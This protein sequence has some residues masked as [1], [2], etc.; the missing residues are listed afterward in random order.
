MLPLLR[1]IA[2]TLLAIAASSALAQAPAPLVV[3]ANDS[4]TTALPII[5]N[6][7][8]EGFLLIESGSGSPARSS[9]DRILGRTA[10]PGVGA[11]INIP[12]DNGR[13]IGTSLTLESNP[14]VGLLC[15]GNS[16]SRSF[17]SLAQHCMVANLSPNPAPP[18]AYSRPGVRAEARLE[19]NRS[20]LTASLGLNRFDIETPLAM[21]GTTPGTVP[22]DR[23][24]SLGGAEFEQ[25]N[26]GLLGE[27]KVGES[28][29]V[30]IG[31]NLARARI[32]PA[33]QLPGGVRPEWNTGTLS[34]GGG[35]G[36]F[37]GEIIGRVI[38]IPGSSNSYSNVGLGVTWRAP[39][40]A[41]LSV[42]AENLATRGKNPFATA[43]KDDEESS[44]VP[45]IRYEQDL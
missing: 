24:L 33:S 9:L 36:N 4:N 28:G 43:E 20:A 17:G 31:G 23:L 25:E 15:N 6:N 32:V 14:T 27:I 19:G 37:G 26:I 7:Q 44:R 10:S 18:L 30:S 35:V 8:V 3:P 2:A 22:S 29:W 12:L 41:R 34:L 11:G 40:R 42:G 5:R 13:R 16:V 38:E 1:P 45:Y 21:P 39:W